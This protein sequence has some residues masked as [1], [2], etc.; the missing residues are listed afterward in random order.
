MHE[1]RNC[2]KPK[3]GDHDNFGAVGNLRRHKQ[4]SYSKG[5]EVDEN[6]MRN[7]EFIISSGDENDFG[8][9][10][11][12]GVEDNEH[13]Y[14]ELD[15]IPNDID[16]DYKGEDYHMEGD[17]VE[18]DSDVGVMDEDGYVTHDYHVRQD[19]FVVMSDH[20]EDYPKGRKITLGDKKDVV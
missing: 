16:V 1:D 7:D 8:R 9:H 18:N 14:S 3:D 19:E 11:T 15:D 13:V 5:E 6:G 10:Q 20:E 17:G 4:T 2:H 12:I